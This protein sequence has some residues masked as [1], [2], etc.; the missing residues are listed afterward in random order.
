MSWESSQ[1][2][3]IGV[4]LLGYSFFLVSNFNNCEVPHKK[5]KK[6]IENVFLMGV[7]YMDRK[8]FVQVKRILSSHFYFSVF[9]EYARVTA[10]YG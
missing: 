6:T 1:G 7:S 10:E 5:R 2:H 3:L 8:L 4:K 9:E